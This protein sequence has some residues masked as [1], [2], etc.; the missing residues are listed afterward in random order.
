MPP[1]PPSTAPASQG[2][3]RIAA[4]ILLS[5]VTGLVREAVFT[6]L[7]GLSMYADAYRAAVKLPNFLQN[8]LGDGTLGASF[9]PVYS[10]LLEQG[11]HEEAGRVAGAVFA[12]LTALAGGLA[13]AG[14]LLARPFVTLILAFPPET[15]EVTIRLVQILFPMTGVL[16]LSAWAMGIQNSHRRFFLSYA[17]GV[18][19]NAAV[20]TAMCVGA[21]GFA[22][23]PRALVV[24][25]AL[26]ALVG[27]LLQFGVQLPQVLKLER[28]LTIRWDTAREGVRETVRNAIPA[29]LGRGVV[30]V[31]GYL[32]LILASML[33]TG[34][35]ASIGA[36]NTLYVLPISLF[37]MSVA[38]AELPELSRQRSAAHEILRE[39]TR[40][41]TERVLF[42][43][44]PSFAAFVAIGDVIV[45][46]LYQGGRFGP[47]A[48]TVVWLVLV[49]YS[50]GLV[51]SSTTRVL[52]SAFFALRDTATPA[53]FATARVAVSAIVGF[54]L[55]AQLEPVR[56]DT[57][58]LA[59]PAG[60]LGHLQ[61]GGY[62]LGAVGL[63]A[64]AGVA[65]WVEWF[66]L[67][68]AL[69]ARIGPVGAR[70][71]TVV[72]V[73]AASVLASAVGFGLGRLLP[74]LPPLITGVL[75][76]AGFGVTYLGGTALLGVGE[77][78][79]LTKRLLRR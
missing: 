74:D 13:L 57:L 78:G 56:Y 7:F 43:V 45:A 73:G 18:G 44:V 12:L 39:R 36:A 38:N 64:G 42:F 51:A 28:N 52:A 21:W 76:C 25:T 15:A 27:G 2:A 24:A 9:I 55:M 50:V 34:A 4:A 49:G 32:D 72:R 8:L 40:T 37:A 5:R 70:W 48:T 75:V 61:V 20:V 10:E 33:T 71:G 77:A 14:V 19:M 35:V 29:V 59:L 41:A 23:E 3:Q 69:S 22:L 62:R 6:Q 67:R 16:V 66:L 60:V 46:S 63:A 65:A 30:Q 1:S 53:R 17:A 47:D 58:G 79:R 68:R 11:R 31:S 26:G 54:A